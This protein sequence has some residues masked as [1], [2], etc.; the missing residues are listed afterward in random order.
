MLF[1][2]RRA[3]HRETYIM[4]Y[5]QLLRITIFMPRFASTILAIVI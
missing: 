5:I 4:R 2:V 3:K 1:T